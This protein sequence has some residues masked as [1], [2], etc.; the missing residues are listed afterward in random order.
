MSELALPAKLIAYI[1]S[2]HPEQFGLDLA[3]AMCGVVVA[4]R[5]AAVPLRSAVGWT[6]ETGGPGSA[7][8]VV[9]KMF[10]D[11]HLVALLVIVFGCLGCKA[12]LRRVA[13]GLLG[14]SKGGAAAA[15]A[16]TAV[17]KVKEE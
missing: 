16:T 10:V 11:A 1:L 8:P 9:S 15:G 3:S 2:D 12:A 5:E 13:S 6:I 17:G 4:A 14:A 7:L